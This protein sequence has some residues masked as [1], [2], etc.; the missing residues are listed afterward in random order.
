MNNN[1]LA[2][3]VGGL[4]VVVAAFLFFGTNVFRRGGPDRDINITVETPAPAPAQ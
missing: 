1:G 4:V 2:L 3:I